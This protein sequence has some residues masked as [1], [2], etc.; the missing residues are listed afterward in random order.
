MKNTLV[1][2]FIFI[3][4]LSGCGQSGS[5]SEDV[6]MSPAEV[7]TLLTNNLSQVKSD[8]K[9]LAF[10]KEEDAKSQAAEQNRPSA[11]SAYQVVSTFSPVVF[12]DVFLADEKVHS[13]NGSEIIYRP[14]SCED[15]MEF[16]TIVAPPVPE[17]DRMNSL[18]DC[19]TKFGPV[20]SSYPV[21]LKA[22]AISRDTLE[23]TLV[24]KSVEILKLVASSDKL[25]LSSSLATFEKDIKPVIKAF[26][27]KP[28]PYSNAS[29]TPDTL[30]ELGQNVVELSYQRGSV[31]L[32]LPNGF[33]SSKNLG[34][35]REQISIPELVFIGRMF[36]DN[37]YIKLGPSSV[38]FSF[39]NK[40]ISGSLGEFAGVFGKQTVNA[41]TS[42]FQMQ[43]EGKEVPPTVDLVINRQTKKA[44]VFVYGRILWKT[45]LSF[46]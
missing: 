34:K 8:E 45:I 44:P 21:Q 27:P 23:L 43:L 4:L 17:N 41:A 18:Q 5:G 39:E 30:G 35:P 20:I 24:S 33:V 6:V 12:S 42:Q 15:L 32:S 37:E 31:S 7:R 28:Q 10:L 13:Q 46:D 9:L 14:L 1:V 26:M 19:R 38:T 40:A 29:E 25:A 16:V 11:Y 2:S 22:K 3:G 36:G